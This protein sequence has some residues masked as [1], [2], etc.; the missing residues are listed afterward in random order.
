[1]LERIVPALRRDCNYADLE[2][3]SAQSAW[4]A[5][6]ERWQLPKFIVEKKLTLPP[7]SYPGR[8]SATPSPAASSSFSDDLDFELRSE[9][10]L[11]D[12]LSGSA[13]RDPAAAYFSRAGSAST[14]DRPSPPAA[15]R[16]SR[17]LAPKAATPVRM[18]PLFR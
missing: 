11:I 6:N 5:L 16:S 1:V 7:V 18:S 13:M 10:R 17:N 12:K 2:R 3:V 14:V 4:D 9:E 15:G 8:T